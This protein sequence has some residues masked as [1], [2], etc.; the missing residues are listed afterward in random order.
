MVNEGLSVKKC[1]YLPECPSN[2]SDQYFLKSLRSIYECAKDDGKEFF[3][4]MHCVFL[5]EF[6]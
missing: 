6:L 5:I 4:K 1:C 2:Y 3:T